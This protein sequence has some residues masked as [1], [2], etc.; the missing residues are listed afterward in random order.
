V[1][2]KIQNPDVLLIYSY[3][4]ILILLQLQMHY[5]IMCREYRKC[6]YREWRG[7]SKVKYIMQRIKI[8][9]YKDPS[10]IK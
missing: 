3:I 7:Y 5:F 8:L 9:P 6:L 4:I 1:K 2:E 10:C